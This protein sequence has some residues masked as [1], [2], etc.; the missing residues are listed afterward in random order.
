[1]PRANGWYCPFCDVVQPRRT[2]RIR[3]RAGAAPLV[4]IQLG[5]RRLHRGCDRRPRLRDCVLGSCAR[6]LEQPVCGDDSS[7]DAA[8]AGP[9]RHQTAE[10]IGAKTDR[11][12]AYIAAAKLYTDADKQDQRSR[13]VAYEQAMRDLAA[14]YPDDREASIFWALSLA[15]SAL[16]TDK[17]YANQ[18]KAGAILE[19]L[20]PEQTNHPG[21]THYIIHSYDVPA[22]AD[23]ARAAAERYATIAPSAPHALHMPSH[24]HARGRGRIRSTPTSRLRRA[25]RR[26]GRGTA[27]D[28]YLV[29]AYLRRVTTPCR[30]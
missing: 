26:A 1:M 18:L 12:R 4:R 11:E 19:K 15:T 2:D 21:I 24:V 25:R 27:R 7:A 10:R 8:D 20:Y 28:H 30:R 5:H 29:Y 6:T 23:K 17:T 9:R 14:K 22:L 16:P 13:V 3:P